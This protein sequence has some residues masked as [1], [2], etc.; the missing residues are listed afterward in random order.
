MAVLTLPQKRR[1]NVR[2]D[3]PPGICRVD[4]PSTRTH[5]F[6]VRLGWHTKNGVPLARRKSYFGDHT[7]GGKRAALRAAKVWLY[8]QGLALR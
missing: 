6:I 7:H 4:Q 8:Q 2:P 1:R 5:G 3:L